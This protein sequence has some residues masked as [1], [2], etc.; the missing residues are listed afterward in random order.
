MT[1]KTAIASHLG[2]LADLILPHL[3]GQPI[4]AGVGLTAL[5]SAYDYDIEIPGLHGELY[6]FQ[7]AGVEYVRRAGRALIGDEMG[8]GKTP[9]AIASLLVTN[10]F[11]AI[12]VCPPSLTL[13]WVREFFH[14][15]PQLKV[16]RL[17]GTKPHALDGLADV[18]V[19]GD[20]VVKNW[21]HAL[22]DLDPRALIVDE[23][24]RMKSRD[25]Q[26]TK[27]VKEIARKVDREGIVVLLSGT[28]IKNSNQELLSQVEIL[29]IT[30]TVFGGVFAYLNR[31]CPKVDRY[32]RGNANS[33]ELH[34]IMRD[35]FF[36]RRLRN[37]VLDLPGKE[38]L[39][40]VIEMSGKAATEY[41]KAEKDLRSYLKALKTEAQVDASMRAEKLVK[42]GVLRR[43][44]GMAK[45][46]NTVEY[47]NDLVEQ[48]DQ[49]IV[50][51]WHRDVVKAYAEAFGADTIMGGDK[52][53]N[54]EA[55]K[56]RFQAGEK[57]VIVL[58]I[59]A[60]GVGHTLTAAKHVVFAEYAWTPGD[61]KQA[62]DRADRIG[63]T[64]LVLSHW[65]IAGNGKATID[66]RLVEILNAK[67]E[68]V[69]MTLDGKAET[70]I[71]T[72]SVQNALL[73]Q[74]EEDDE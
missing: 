40:V 23:S 71:D 59:E 10:T 51:A 57:K 16:E 48:G 72:D 54:V 35:H 32:S 31:Y 25:A 68:R 43:L 50:F 62:E 11:P 39:P 36:V 8:L 69:G 47:V 17:V 2:N 22:I 66:E 29:G 45:I 4:K 6:P 42:L 61:M 64:Q 28:A 44:A 27:A 5:S 70:M 41:K 18:Y 53:E 7:K 24:H 65:L 55:A 13:N 20:A 34:E 56:A 63:Q 74:Y 52:V 46:Q 15:A 21:Q 19:I 73:A 9:Q 58:N 14:F 33:Q 49:V 60:G 38:R 67:G 37:E 1:T 3:M 26:R 30:D 12:V